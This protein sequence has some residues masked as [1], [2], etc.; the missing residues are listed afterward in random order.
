MT[1]TQPPLEMG[2]QRTINHLLSH[3]SYTC[4]LVPRLAETPITVEIAHFLGEQ[5][6]QL[7]SVFD[8]QLGNIQI[9]SEY[10]LW[11]VMIMPAV[12]IANIIRLIRQR[13]SKR[14]F[15]Q[16]SDLNNLNDTGDFWAPGFLASSN[17]APLTEASIEDF[18]NQTRRR[19]ELIKALEA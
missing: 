9:Q 13:T 3:Q 15:S 8:W 18:I 10:M 16:F 19:Q 1:T 4:I 2:Y 7:A 14:I 5:M 12:P 17:T 11:T 6:T